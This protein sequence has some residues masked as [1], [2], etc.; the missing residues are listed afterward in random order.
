M[1]C[2]CRV[3]CIAPSD[4]HANPLARFGSKNGDDIRYEVHMDNIRFLPPR[5]GKL[6]GTSLLDRG[7]ISRKVSG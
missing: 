6:D 4:L 7:E 1:T 3:A 2:R 5:K